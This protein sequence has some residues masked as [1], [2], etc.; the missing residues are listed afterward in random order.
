MLPR[1]HTLIF[2]RPL[3]WEYSRL[4]IG[5]T[6]LSKRKIQHLITEG[7]CDD[8]DDPRL[9]T[10]L[11][12]RRRGFPPKAINAFVEGLGLTVAQTVVHPAALESHVRAE[13]DDTAHRVM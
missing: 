7:I 11:A 5:Y 10:L 13:L 3:Q 8:W 4:N 1:R 2:S 9:Y 12:L 6:V